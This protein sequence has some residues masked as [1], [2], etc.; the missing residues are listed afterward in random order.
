[1]NQDVV[2]EAGKLLQ[3]QKLSI[4]FAE[5]ATAGRICA[6][7][8]L[9]ENAGS[10]LKGAIACYDACIKESLLG[11]EH[12]LIEKFTPESMEVTR[13]ITLG[14][15][16][17]IP[18]DIHIGVTGL[19]CAGGSETSEKP[20]GTVFIFALYQGEPA[21]SER[22]NFKG[23]QQAIIEATV[24]SCAMLLKTFLENIQNMQGYEIKA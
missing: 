17:I 19:S 1:M 14:L 21:F 6:E 15:S 12:E 5:S 23:E 16:K 4:A 11:V 9:L 3:N 8:S 20:V 2:N 10:F 24:E 7:F 18:A 22:L 13:A